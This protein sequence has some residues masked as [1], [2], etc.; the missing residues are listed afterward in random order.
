M[1][2]FAARFGKATNLI[3]SDVPLAEDR[4]RAV[5]P[6]IFAEG[7]HTSRSDRYTYIPTIEILRGL[8]REG[9][10]PYMVAQGKSRIE[11]KAEYTK[12]LVRMRYAEQVNTRPEVNE[13]IL[14]NSHDGASTYQM[15]AGVFRFVCLNG[16][17][18]GQMVEDIRI[19][20]KGDV[21][22]EVIEGAFRV[23]DT[24]KQIDESV[25]T[26]KA[27]SLNIGEQSAFASAALAL[28]FGDR[29]AEGAAPAPVTAEQINEP[30]RWDDRGQSL[31]TTFQRIQENTTKGGIVGRSAEGRR[32]RTRA[33]NGID[34]NVALNRA[35]WVLADEM[36]KL[37]A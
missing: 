19:P 15:L 33:V 16:M 23:V 32:V 21:Q 5:A 35:L 8:D 1:R 12:H 10:K 13:I 14:I 18:T 4:M 22:H 25:S 20:H 30:R 26:M 3:R 29:S 34:G 6:S 17:V 24:F 7:K 11:G 28:R 36:R 31:W 37:K 2:P 27:L 9:F